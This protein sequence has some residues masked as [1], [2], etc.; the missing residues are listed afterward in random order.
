M[1]EKII[2]K[3]VQGEGTGYT[4]LVWLI[5]GFQ[6]VSIIALGMGKFIFNSLRNDIKKLFDI[7][8]KRD[9]DCMRHEGQIA[10]LEGKMGVRNE[11]SD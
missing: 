8:E 2:A 4:V 1:P 9:T 3:A 7:I 11:I 10:K 5:A 6:L